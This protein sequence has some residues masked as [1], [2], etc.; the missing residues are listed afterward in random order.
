[1][2]WTVKELMGFFEKYYGERYSGPALGVMT[3][4]LDGYSADFLKATAD[5]M[6]KRFSRCYGKAPCPADIERHMDEIMA[7][8]PKPERLPEPG[9]EMTREERMDTL[10]RLL[11]ETRRLLNT[12]KAEPMTRTLTNLCGDYE[13]KIRG[14]G[15]SR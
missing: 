8:M 3:G 1:M 4:Y 2:T 7:A 10:G 5:V 11:D 12:G 6:I 14:I 9:F 15:G 13:T